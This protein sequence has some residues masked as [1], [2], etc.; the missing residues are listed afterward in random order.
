MVL[1]S[2]VKFIITTDWP[3]FASESLGMPRNS[4]I[5]DCANA[6]QSET[7]NWFHRSSIGIR[8]PRRSKQGPQWYTTLEAMAEDST[9]IARQTRKML[10]YRA[11]RTHE[12]RVQV[13]R[14][15]QAS[16]C[17]FLGLCNS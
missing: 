3:T 5:Q 6:S 1:G 15:T 10:S 8:E 9:A 12:F 7:S 11:T 17:S 13:G 2:G 16:S 4:A 14:G